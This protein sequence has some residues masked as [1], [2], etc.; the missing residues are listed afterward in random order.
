MIRRCSLSF[1]VFVVVACTAHS[2]HAQCEIPLTIQQG[3]SAANVLFLL[4][5]SGSM[6]SAI[7]HEDFDNYAT[8]SGP[9]GSMQTFTVSSDG[10]YS[11]NSFDDDLPSTPLAPLIQSDSGN[12]AR[13]FGNYLNW[14]F[15]HATQEQRDALPQVTRMEVGKV[16]IESV[17]NSSTGLRFGLMRLNGDTGGIVVSDIGTDPATLIADLNTLTGGGLTPTAE[18]MVDALTYFQTTGSS[19]PIQAACQPSYIIVVTDGFPTQD[20][21]VPSYIG[22]QD[23]DGNEPG[24]CSSIGALEPNSANCSDYL[25]DVAY[26][27]A[28]TDV[29]SDLDGD[30]FVNTFTIGMGID[31]PL[32]AEAAA[33]GGGTYEVAWNLATLQQSLGSALT[34][35]LAG[36][37]TGGA[38]AVVS[39][40]GA[41]QD[42]LYRAKYI[43]GQWAGYLEAYNLPYTQGASPVWEAGALL[44]SRSESS[45]NIFTSQGGVLVDF[46]DAQ[47]SA[48]VTSLGTSGEGDPEQAALDIIEF[49]RGKAISGMRDRGGWKLGDVIHSSP[50]VVG[51]P[52]AFIVDESYQSYLYFHA[53]R[54]ETVYVGGNDGMLHAF[55]ASTGQ[56]RWGYV[57]ESL[58]GKLVD[59]TDPAFCHKAFVDLTP[60][61]FE[62][63]VGGTWRTVL[64]GG[65]R[66]GGDAYFALDVTD[67]NSPGVLW[68]T[69]VPEIGS[70]F[71]RPAMVRKTNATYLW[72]GSG[73]D[74]GGE[75]TVALLN[76]VTGAVEFTASVGSLHSDVNAASEAVVYD[77]DWDGDADYLYQGDLAG[78]LWRWD[79]RDQDPANWSG[80]VLFSGSQPIQ[81]RPSVSINAIGDALVYFGTG[82]YL[83]NSDLANTDMQSFYCVIDDLTQSY[84]SR[85][86]L[87]DQTSSP[88]E[89]QSEPGWY[90]DL[91]QSPGERVVEPAR[92]IE[93]VAYFTSFSPESLL[94]EIGGNSWLYHMRFHDGLAM[95]GGT[96]DRVTSVG[97]GIA[98]T[99]VVD[100]EEGE[101]T[102]QTSDARISFFDMNASPRRVI[103]NNWREEFPE[104]EGLGGQ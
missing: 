72:V 85:S 23:G 97:E 93:G 4:D 90:I 82:R 19:A 102:V 33:N 63:K 56:E 42:R 2:A 41:S 8:Y 79:I 18:A 7:T 1:V 83:Q 39:N 69:S 80:T 91:V 61:A 50:L 62:F 38:A 73:P 52:R 104:I 74:V 77:N 75:A 65:T 68:E 59:L 12:N 14:I 92:V 5:T 94:C 44:A 101:L 16:A 64:V 67:P 22:D 13:Y 36:V 31:I 51:P 88:S 28:H 29:R 37:T 15:Y 84:V 40:E 55:D 47:A 57:P 17:I 34:A 66:T 30:Q 46:N 3:V 24:D 100:L 9:F 70:S 26:Y 25:D 71:T 54:P 81:A 87:V 21:D 48:L 78:N 98:S 86:S 35:I 11:P 49:V 6:R 27:L 53:S 60:A 95:D 103:V 43:P 58:L 45:R 76:A 89:L 20:L 99:P 96:S 10:D 32:L